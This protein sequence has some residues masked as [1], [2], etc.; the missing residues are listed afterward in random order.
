[1]K[2]K[3]FIVNVLESYSFGMMTCVAILLLVG[4]FTVW[5]FILVGTGILL[6]IIAMGYVVRNVVTIIM[7]K[8]HEKKVKYAALQQ[9]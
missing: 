4:I 3:S 7:D 1:M 9:R 2:K 8:L 6:L 5:K